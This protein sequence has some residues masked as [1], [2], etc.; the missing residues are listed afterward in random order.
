MPTYPHDIETVPCPDH[1]R[2][3]NMNY[4]Q[5]LVRWALGVPPEFVWHP[6]TLSWRR[7]QDD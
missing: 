6:E 5:P 7:P 2:W 3:A 1:Y 4:D